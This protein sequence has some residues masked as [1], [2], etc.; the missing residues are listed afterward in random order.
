MIIHALNVF[1]TP[2]EEIGCSEEE[3]WVRFVQGDHVRKYDKYDF[4]D[5]IIKSGFTLELVDKLYFDE[6]I[7]NDNDLTETSTLYIVKK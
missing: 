5:R 3:N 7:Y 2:D 6:N 1:R 4:I